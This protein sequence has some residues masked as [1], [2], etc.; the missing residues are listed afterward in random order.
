[1]KYAGYAEFW[2]PWTGQCEAVR[3]KERQE[4]QA[5]AVRIERRECLIVAVDPSREPVRGDVALNEWTMTEDLSSGW[6]VAAGPR[7]GD[8]PELESWTNWDGMGHYS[9]TVA[10]E[11]IFDLDHPGKWEQI[12]LDLG[13]AHE[14]VRLEVNGREV[15]CQMW[16]PYRF[17]IGRELKPGL[18]I[19]RVSVT[20]SLANRYDGKSL[21][22][23][24]L[25]PVRLRGAGLK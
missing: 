11:N 10:Y 16:K 2:R 25:G 1:M 21:P 17:G 13:E 3:I 12:E 19:L 22:S 15:G 7:T 5:A 4:G 6:R 8:L 14:F 24:L 9:G 18:N 20:N 23:G